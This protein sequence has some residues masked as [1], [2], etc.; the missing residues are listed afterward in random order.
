M[1]HLLNIN[2][3]VAAVVVATSIHHQQVLQMLGVAVVVDYNTLLVPNSFAGAVAEVV[4]SS[5]PDETGVVAVDASGGGDA[6]DVDDGKHFEQ[7]SFDD[8]DVV[9][10]ADDDVQQLPYSVE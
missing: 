6:D 9:A 1:N 4:A 3:Y 7:P 2:E 8:D 10:V 5:Y